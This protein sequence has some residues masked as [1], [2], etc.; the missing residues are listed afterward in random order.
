MYLI[1]FRPL[2]VLGRPFLQDFVVEGVEAVA[3]SSRSLRQV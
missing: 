3:A 2:Q 1:Y